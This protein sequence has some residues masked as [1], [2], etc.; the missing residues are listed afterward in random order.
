MSLVEGQREAEVER[1]RLE[2][3][4]SGYNKKVQSGMLLLP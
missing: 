1:L 2:R 4:D 3:E